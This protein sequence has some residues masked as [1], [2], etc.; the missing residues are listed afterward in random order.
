LTFINI[1]AFVQ[2]K[3]QLYPLLS[4]L[5]FWWWSSLLATFW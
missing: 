2:R 1:N 5:L 3:G 4:L